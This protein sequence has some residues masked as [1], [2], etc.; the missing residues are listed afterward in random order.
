VLGLLAMVA[1]EATPPPHPKEIAQLQPEPAIEQALHRAPEAAAPSKEL[2]RIDDASAICM[3]SNRYLPGRKNVPAQ[4]DEH[5]YYGC[6][7][8]CAAQLAKNEAARHAV[9]PVNG[10]AIDKANAVLARDAR[11]AVLY[12]ESEA[13]FAEYRGH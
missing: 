10:H 12:F 5:T 4:V 9:D 1:C 3:L 6:C 2:T 13:T 8:G 7:A 11:N